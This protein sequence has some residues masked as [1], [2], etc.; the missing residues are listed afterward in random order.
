MLLNKRLTTK[1]FNNLVLHKHIWSLRD[2]VP[3]PSPKSNQ[4]R[5]FSPPYLWG[6]LTLSCYMYPS[7]QTHLHLRRVL[8]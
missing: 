6:A 3:S 1:I 8:V 7:M 5:N 2:M 4:V